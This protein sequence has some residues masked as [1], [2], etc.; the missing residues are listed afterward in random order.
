MDAADF[1][2]AG[3]VAASQLLTIFGTG[4]GPATG[5]SAKNYSTTTLAGVSVSFGSTLAPL[6]YVSSTQIDLAVPGG[7]F[8]RTRLL[9]PAELRVQCR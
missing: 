1:T 9:N 6:L 7:S 8:S 5:L 2:D 4:L 3:P